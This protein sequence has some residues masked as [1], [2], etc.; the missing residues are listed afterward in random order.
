MKFKTLMI[1]IGA[2]ILALASSY[3]RETSFEIIN[4]RLIGYN[5][6]YANTAPPQWLLEMEASELKNLKWIL[7]GVFLVINFLLSITIVRFGLSRLSLRLV[8]LGYAGIVMVATLFFLLESVTQWKVF[9]A[10]FRTFFSLT[11]G[12]ILT[13]ILGALSFTFGKRTATL[14]N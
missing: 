2:M 7:S 6:N 11:Q 4:Y 12:P 14:G 3:L 10:M 5:H 9:E 1:V 8:T 13:L